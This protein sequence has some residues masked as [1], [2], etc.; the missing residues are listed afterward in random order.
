MAAMAEAVAEKGYAATTV[1]DVLARAGVSRATFYGLFRSKEECFLATYQAGVEIVTAEVADVLAAVSADTEPD[2]LVRLD[3]VLTAYL[4]ALLA[5]PALARTF[6][7]EV[8]AAGPR[9]IE[10][11]RRSLDRFVDIVAETH[12]G[13]TGLLG[14]EPEQRFAAEALV[15]AISSMVTNLV[16]VGDLDGIRALRGPL[17][18]LARTMSTPPDAAP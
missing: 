1:A 8:Y 15:G 2:L 18:E 10:L 14:T 11:R 3:R 6:L 9:A 17:L 12:R 7:L 4:D 5:R 16:G 13:S